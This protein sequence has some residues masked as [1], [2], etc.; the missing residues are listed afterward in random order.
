VQRIAV[1]TLVPDERERIRRATERRLDHAEWIVLA[2]FVRHPLADVPSGGRNVWDTVAS[3]AA[4]D[5]CD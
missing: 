1:V 3:T 5:V 2:Q 4:L